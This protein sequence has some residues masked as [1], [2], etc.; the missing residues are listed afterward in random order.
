MDYK[1]MLEELA[2]KIHI[3][4]L[5]C[6]HRFE[7]YMDASY[8]DNRVGKLPLSERE[9]PIVVEFAQDV[10]K[11]FYKRKVDIPSYVERPDI[12]QMKAGI[13]SF[14][15][16]GVVGAFVGTVIAELVNGNKQTFATYGAVIGII[17]E[18]LTETIYRPLLNTFRE[19]AFDDDVERL[20]NVALKKL[21]TL[22]S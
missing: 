20:Q 15:A 8:I 4:L 13:L 17:A 18:S 11:T 19:W 1:P 22:K 2:A 14:V 16:S 5:I 10:R 3:D 21:N 7:R 6:E 12:P 9:K